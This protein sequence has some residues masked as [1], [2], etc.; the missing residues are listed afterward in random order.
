ML[1][2]KSSSK[3]TTCSANFCPWP[4]T[5]CIIP[6]ADNIWIW[7]KHQHGENGDELYKAVI[8]DSSKMSDTGIFIPKNN[9]TDHLPTRYEYVLNRMG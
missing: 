4:K 5:T 8:A 3:F 9:F 1:R 2:Q 7:P 6:V